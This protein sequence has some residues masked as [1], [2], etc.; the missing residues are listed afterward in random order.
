L[1]EAKMI[2]ERKDEI[3]TEVWGKKYFGHYYVD[4]KGLLTVNCGYGTEKAMLTPGANPKSLAGI[5]LAN[6]IKETLKK[7]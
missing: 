3:T 2:P 6:I 4:D 5:M 7:K 1:E